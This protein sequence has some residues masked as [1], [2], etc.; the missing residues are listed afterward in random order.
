MQ[1][2]FKKGDIVQLRSGGPKMTV[3]KYKFEIRSL[4][5]SGE[6]MH[7]VICKWFDNENNLVSHDFEQEALKLYEK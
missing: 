4:N 5:D 6:S 7:V 2:M 3:E 1:Q